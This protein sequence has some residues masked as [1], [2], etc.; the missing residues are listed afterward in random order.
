MTDTDRER[1]RCTFGQD[2]ELYDRARPGYPTRLFQD[3]AELAGLNP[4]S[5]VLEIGCGTGRATRPIAQLGCDIV[6]VELN[7]E[8]AA[9]ADRNLHH[10]PNLTIEVAPFET[11][12]PPPA[13]S[14]DLVVSATAFHWIDPAV[15]VHKAADLLRPGGTLALID[16][17]HVAGG[18][19]GFFVDA[20][21]CYE[22]FDPATTPGWRQPTAVDI[23]DDPSEIDRSQRFGTVQFRRNEWER[24]YTT[25]SYLDLLRTYSSTWALP[26]P[27][28]DGLLACLGHLSDRNHAGKVS[29]RYSTG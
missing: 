25:R 15:R 17:D 9:A 10:F 16:T 21:N 4:Q 13:T 26:Q 12:T 27:S 19:P 6:A 7:P 5:R 18:T 20:Q 23:L 14:F 28:R 8:M 1:L 2:A 11:W 3:L 22:R 29:K 24:S